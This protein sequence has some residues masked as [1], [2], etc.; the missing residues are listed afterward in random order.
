M[1]EWTVVP[2]LKSQMKGQSASPLALMDSLVE[3]ARLSGLFPDLA[4]YLVDL[5]WN[6][7]RLGT[8][9]DASDETLEEVIISL[10][11]KSRLPWQVDELRALI[12]HMAK[13]WKTRSMLKGRWQTRNSGS[14]FLG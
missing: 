10:E 5:G 8:L 12:A 14:W 2:R 1:T 7:Q 6:V 13:G 9:E 11:D 4:G 3:L